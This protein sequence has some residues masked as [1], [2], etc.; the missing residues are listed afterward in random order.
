M[1]WHEALG[2]G[3][4][5]AIA[6]SH[7]PVGTRRAPDTNR[8]EGQ[9][10]VLR[11]YEDGRGDSHLEELVVA[12]TPDGRFRVAGDLP[13]VGVALR[14]YPADDV[15]DWHRAPARQFA[16]TVVGELEV[17]VWGGMRRTVRAGELVFLEDTRGKG[18]IT[19]LRGRVTNLFI[20]VPDSFDVVVWARGHTPT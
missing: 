10:R 8:A 19:R 5:A 3:G 16:I 17:E 12:T 11:V 1:D 6:L 7:L 13:A 15:V 18:H 20:R 4:L 9:T 14:E 2:F